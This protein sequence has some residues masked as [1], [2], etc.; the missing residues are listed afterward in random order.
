[1]PMRLLDRFIPPET[2]DYSRDTLRYDF[3]SGIAKG[4]AQVGGPATAAV[5]AKKAF[6]ANDFVV[7]M[8]YTAGHAGQVLSPWVVKVIRGRR[9]I[10]FIFR[11]EA[12]SMALLAISAFMS[13]SWL[14]VGVLSFSYV[15][16]G[17]INP[18][19]SRVYRHNY[20][21][22][23][24]GQLF[25]IVRIGYNASL[26]VGGFVT[27]RLLDVDPGAY[28]AIY[29]ALGLIGLVGS[30]VFRQIKVHGEEVYSP[31]SP[32]GAARGWP[33]L[34]DVV[35]TDRRYVV[36]LLIWAV[37]G[38]ANMMMDPVRAIFITDARYNVNAD[39]LQSLLILLVVPQV[40]VLLTLP[41]WGRLLDRYSVSIMRVWLQLFSGLDL[42]VFLLAWR[43]EC[44][45]LAS[46]MKGLQMAGAQVTWT[47]GIM[48]FA[49][50]DRV[51]EYT[52]LHTLFT[53]IRGL[54]APQL[55]ALLMILIGPK[56]VF[57]LGICAFAASIALF[58]LFPRMTA[59]WP[60]PDGAPARAVPVA[61]R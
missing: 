24:R 44:L 3:L 11:I 31:G 28:G 57:V 45:Y 36:F 47:I 43:V 25:G 39:Y 16:L 40:T 22:Q 53:G 58:L 7:A 37:F 2:P 6:G 23:M 49:P 29:P 34:L 21:T 17:A 51:T 27:G 54:I 9:V 38:F 18:A 30:L 33:A 32:A 52:A 35:T 20:P 50:R 12:A 26:A 13:T 19:F 48:E 4:I 59:S 5:I 14:F 60:I 1:M 8:L 42:V 55:A 56:G 10:P 41:L 61:R 46:V 15:F